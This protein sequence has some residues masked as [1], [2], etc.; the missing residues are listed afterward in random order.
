MKTIITFFFFVFFSYSLVAAEK[1]TFKFSNPRIENYAPDNYLVFDVMV[2]ASANGT[3]LY[4]SQVI[5]NISLANFNT[6]VQPSADK[7]TFITGSYDPPG[8]PITAFE[9]YSVSANYNSGNL[10]ISVLANANLNAY[11]IPGHSEV[12]TTWQTLCTV[13]CLVSNTAGV[14]GVSFQP[15]AMNGYQKFATGV[16]PLYSDYYASPN[17]YEGYDFADLY[18]ARIY[19]GQY[20]WTQAGGVVD[21][22]ASVN[23]SVWDTTA[24]AAFVGD[25]THP[26]ALA[27]GLKIYPL[28]R[29][30][31]NPNTTLTV[32]GILNN[33]AGNSGLVIKS[34]SSSTGS[35]LHNTDDVSATIQRDISQSSN[36]SI[37]KYHFV[38][39]PLKQTENP[40]SAL[41]LGSYLFGYDE[42]NNQWIAYGAAT[43]TPLSIDKG[44]MINYPNTSITYSFSGK[45]NNGTLSIPVSYSSVTPNSTTAGF[46]LVPNPYPS[47]IDWLAADGWVKTNIDNAIYI[48]PARAPAPAENYASFIDGVSLNGGSR[49]IAQGQ[50]FI[51]H[52]NNSGADFQIKNPSRVHN[53]VMFFK[54]DEIVPNV[55]R[56]ESI[57]NQATDEIVVRFKSEATSGFDGKYD[58]YK[59][60]GGADAPQLN[61]VASDDSKLCINALPF[62]ETETVVP[63]NFSF[64]ASTNVTFTA[65]GMET[66]TGTSPIY[67]EDGL[68]AKL[69]NLR[70]NP[71][72]SFGY[73]PG[74]DQNRFKL[75]FAKVV[76]IKEV[77][78][79]AV[80]TAYISD[81]KLYIDVPSMNGQKS[82]VGVYNSLGQRLNLN[83]L[84]MNGMMEL[85]F[86]LP[87]GIYIVRATSSSQVFTSKLVN[88]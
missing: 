70:E 63:L 81:M 67:L 59:M 32:A 16:G 41:F 9:K 77:Q 52:A 69:I 65:S 75:R 30:A 17:L 54:D 78:E 57:A 29:L 84:T 38:S 39:V 86:T 51:I 23:T 2:K 60:A 47:A 83:R 56:I 50:S 4:A 1:L 42:G 44:Y 74:S 10:N 88:N 31:I 12:T 3:Y 11:K 37:F 34:N 13:Y 73:E 87:P 72:Y 19:C 22:A 53:P 33:A 79:P 48:W 6:S 24:A 26:D 25:V 27:N 71:L 7:G 43:T 8:P 62:S 28:G 46:N 64:T 55:L 15:A 58:A 61:S 36:E 5:C 40:K 21:W 35:L 82:E 66:F 76:G 14:A 85:P 80:G 18:L 20:G 68:T 49:Y 45:I